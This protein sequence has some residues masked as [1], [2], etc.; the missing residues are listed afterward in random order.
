MK[1]I[2]LVS[3][4]A[5][6]TA[7]LLLFSGC[8]HALPVLTTTSVAKFTAATAECGGKITF[9]GR[10][11][12]TSYGICYDTKPNPTIAN[13][14]TA[15]IEPISGEFANTI[16]GLTANKTYYIRAYATNSAGTAYGEQISFTTIISAPLLLTSSISDITSNSA[17]CGNIILSTGGSVILNCGICWDTL[18]KPTVNSSKT[19][20]YL[21]PNVFLSHLG[22]LNPNRSYFVRA[23]ATNSAGT[24]YGEEKIFT[25]I[26]T[27]PYLNTNPVSD[28][29][30][31]TA[32]CGAKII[33]DGGTEISEHG[34]CWST[35]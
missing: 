31:N 33:S 18:P 29:S 12:F 25:T 2:C 23:Y 9:E 17:I 13:L 10:P 11:E 28:I 5:I 7:L 16:S 34:I 27:V 20:D 3:L 6:T 14:R 30:L 22:G 8:K 1:R 15:H 24:G 32:I 19:I 35:K 4:C 26:K 21:I